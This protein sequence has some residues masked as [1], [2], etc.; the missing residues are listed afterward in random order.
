MFF[1]MVLYLHHVFLLIGF[2]RTSEAA[3]LSSM[4]SRGVEKSAD[5]G[6]HVSRMS[7]PRSTNWRPTLSVT[8]ASQQLLIA[9]AIF[10]LKLAC[11]AMNNNGYS[12]L[13]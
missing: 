1:Q 3:A 12:K 9:L 7:M 11:A 2:A 13:S 4:Q 10:H 8:S 5:L 6:V